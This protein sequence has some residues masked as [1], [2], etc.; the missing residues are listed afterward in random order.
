MKYIVKNGMIVGQYDTREEAEAHHDELRKQGYLKVEVKET[1]NADRTAA[2]I[3]LGSLGGKSTS[4]AKKKA[5]REN[6][7]KGGRPRKDKC[8]IPTLSR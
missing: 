8:T 1:D 3:A 4:D 6:G 5:A 2:A 7:K